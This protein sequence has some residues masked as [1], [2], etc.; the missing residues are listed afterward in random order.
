M[1]SGGSLKKGPKS[2]VGDVIR[3]A[4][5]GYSKRRDEVDYESLP[6]KVRDE[7]R[8][9]GLGREK[10]EKLAETAA[11]RRLQ[12]QLVKGNLDEISKVAKS[13]SGEK[14]RVKNIKDAFEKIESGELDEMPE[15]VTNAACDFNQMAVPGA[16][17]DSLKFKTEDGKKTL[18]FKDG[19]P[20]GMVPDPITG[21]PR[22]VYCVPTSD[23]NQ[24][25]KGK[26]MHRILEFNR[27]ADLKEYE[28]KALVN[29]L[30]TSVH[31]A[32]KKIQAIQEK[33]GLDL[34]EI[35]PTFLNALKRAIGYLR[36]LDNSTALMEK[37][38]EALPN[39]YRKKIIHALQDIEDLKAD[40]E[41]R[42]AKEVKGDPILAS[43][44]IKIQEEVGR[45][46]NLLADK[47][48]K[49]FQASVLKTFKNDTNDSCLAPENADPEVYA[50][51][52]ARRKNGD[53]DAISKDLARSELKFPEI[54][55]I[56]NIV[57]FKVIKNAGELMGPKVYDEHPVP[58]MMHSV[59]AC[60]PY[61]IT[62]L[63]AGSPLVK[64]WLEMIVDAKRLAA[65]SIE[66]GVKSLDKFFRTIL[67][68]SKAHS[69][70]LGSS[71]LRS[72]SLGGGAGDSSDED[73]SDEDSDSDLEGGA[74]AASLW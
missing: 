13:I 35:D 49:L 18:R 68:D 27:S 61:F 46:M 16:L 11:G 45:N 55:T 26:D 48:L 33:D 43:Y 22:R 21:K 6:P 64:V 15:R 51:L 28:M 47:I 63:P 50:A 19:I 3:A 36:G 2:F 57:K 5:K 59:T 29:Q 38:T 31:D 56:D 66:E 23:V 25:P 52:M 73:S 10:F 71:L 42:A 44:A 34:E 8:A 54:E 24:M 20:V 69:P 30:V 7:L 39:Y 40:F 41:T 62:K 32:L 12:K 70:S 4:E 53:A 17:P 14:K 65:T 74:S 60:V 58:T 67:F 37:I 1:L 72:P 9:A